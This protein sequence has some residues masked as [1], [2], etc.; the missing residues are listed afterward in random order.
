RG[1]P[2]ST[3]PTPWPPLDEDARIIWRTDPHER[4]RL[5]RERFGR[6]LV[7]TMDN[8]LDYAVDKVINPRP[9]NPCEIE[10]WLSGLH[11]AYRHSVSSR[12]DKQKQIVLRLVRDVVDG[13]LLQALT[14]L[15][16]FYV[17]DVKIALVGKGPDGQAVEAPVT[18]IEADLAELFVRCTEEFSRYSTQLT[19]DLKSPP[20]P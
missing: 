9:A 3:E 5:A 8:Y 13:V 20:Q 15:D 14:R 7:E 4:A 19:D 12:S 6:A 16:Q 2:V 10:N 11:R 1:C 18:S 17:A